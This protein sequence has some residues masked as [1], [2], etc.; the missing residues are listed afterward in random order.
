MAGALPDIRLKG[1]DGSTNA[2]EEGREG[3]GSWS[4]E[5]VGAEEPRT[6]GAPPPDDGER[7]GPCRPPVAT[8]FRPLQSGNPRGGGQG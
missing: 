8:R 1:M 3:E 7:A 5:Q 4:Q 6:A 2:K